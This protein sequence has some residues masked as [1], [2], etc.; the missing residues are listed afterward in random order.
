MGQ[1]FL[2]RFCTRIVTKKINSK[3]SGFVG[4]EIAYYIWFYDAI[5]RHFRNNIKTNVSLKNYFYGN[6]AHWPLLLEKLPNAI[7]AQFCAPHLFCTF[8]IYGTLRWIRKK[9][10]NFFA[11]SKKII[12]EKILVSLR[13]SATLWL[14]IAILISKF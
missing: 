3:Y 6:A 4:S 11:S 9:V 12:E 5:S 2:G 10:Q 14:Q 8:E 1:I 7:A 13:K